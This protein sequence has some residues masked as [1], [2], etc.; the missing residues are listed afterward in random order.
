[1]LAALLFVVPFNVT[2]FA[3]ENTLFLL[4]PTRAPGASPGDLGQ[5]GRQVVFFLL[6]LLTVMLACGLSAGAGFAAAAMAGGPVP[7]G[8][9]AALL[10]LT[11]TAVAMVPVTG[12]AYRSFDPS[13]DTPA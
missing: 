8:I 9:A 3:L 1:M 2:L 10:A 6:K 11:I 7:V 12:W 5:M 13:A 4:F